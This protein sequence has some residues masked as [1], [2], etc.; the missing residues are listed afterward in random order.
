VI[1]GIRHVGYN[2]SDLAVIRRFYCDVLGFKEI[3]SKVEGDVFMSNLWRAEGMVHTVKFQAPDG[4][5]LEFGLKPPHLWH[6]DLSHIGLVTDDIEA[7]YKRLSELGWHFV[8]PPIES[9]EG[10]KLAVCFG[11]DGQAIELV[12][13]RNEW[14]PPLPSI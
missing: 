5:V 4:H 11:P 14:V 12:E 2:C 7:E 10:N 3:W 9:P 13:V 1:T 6:V 8:S